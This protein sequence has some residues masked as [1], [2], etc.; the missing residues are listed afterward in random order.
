MC[1]AC[2]HGG[3]CAGRLN[4]QCGRGMEA[5]ETRRAAL[6]PHLA[7]PLAGHAGVGEAKVKGALR[8]VEPLCGEPA[9]RRVLAV[10]EHGRRRREAA[11]HLAH[12]VGGGAARLRGEA[13]PLDGSAG[14][15]LRV[16]RVAEVLG[17]VAALHAALAP[18]VA[19]RNAALQFDG[20]RRAQRKVASHHLLCGPRRRRPAPGWRR[21]WLCR[22]PPRSAFSGA[23]PR[24]SRRGACTSR[25]RSRRRRAPRC[26]S[27]PRSRQSRCCRRRSTLWHPTFRDGSDTPTRRGPP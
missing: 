16:E 21:R 6:A 3:A 23:R 8:G 9:V 27:R 19:R 22:Q 12:V 10:A 11:H 4:C 26:P 25:T 14:D 17:R 15:L 13:R 5:L 1:V 2:T 7:E 24:R 20:R 18:C